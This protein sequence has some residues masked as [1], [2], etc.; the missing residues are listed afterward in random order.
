VLQ[1]TSI[2][3]PRY[4]EHPFSQP[5]LDQGLPGDS[6]GHIIM[7]VDVSINVV[8]PFI[9]RFILLGGPA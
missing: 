9:G 3:R 5:A 1:Q 6:H 2:E 4:H 7:L 8:V